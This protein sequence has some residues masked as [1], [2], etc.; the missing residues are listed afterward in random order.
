MCADG[1]DGCVKGEAASAVGPRGDLDSP[2]CKTSGLAG[3][4]GLPAPPSCR[5]QPGRAGE[6]GG[7]QGTPSSASPPSRGIRVGSHE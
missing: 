4:Q 2:A 1:R 5:S 6:A 7:E 3:R